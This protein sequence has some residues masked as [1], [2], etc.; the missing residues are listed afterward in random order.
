MGGYLAWETASQLL[1]LGV[2][3]AEI[4]FFEAPLRKDF[5]NVRA[6][7]IPV[8]TTNVWRLGHHYAP[9][10]LPVCLTHLMTPAWHETRW[11]RPWQDLALDGLEVVVL[12]DDDIAPR[13]ERLA[14]ALRAWCQ[15]ADVSRQA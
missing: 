7:P 13:A 10:P 3:I 6:G 11:W 5:A 4:C 1:K 15:R 14:L 8:E 9:T 12:A 2:E